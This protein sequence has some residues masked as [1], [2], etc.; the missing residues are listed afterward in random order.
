MPPSS[1][2][3][4]K[5]LEFLAPSSTLETDDQKQMRDPKKNET[6]KRDDDNYQLFITNSLMRLLNPIV[7]NGIIKKINLDHILKLYGLHPRNQKVNI[8]KP[9]KKFRLLK[10]IIF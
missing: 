1:E 9:N 8:R 6:K 5:P 4:V 2:I 10:V 7:N 3:I